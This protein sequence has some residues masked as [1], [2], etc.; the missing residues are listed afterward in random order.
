MKYVLNQSMNTHQ[1]PDLHEY[2]IVVVLRRLVFG[3][4]D[5]FSRT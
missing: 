3:D 2:I 1:S 4:F 5:L